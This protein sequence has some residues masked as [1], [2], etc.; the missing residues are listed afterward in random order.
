MI[1]TAIKICTFFV[2]ITVL[3]ACSSMDGKWP[4]LTEPLPSDTERE[5]VSEQAEPSTQTPPAPT[6]TTFTKSG[7]IKLFIR[8]ETELAVAKSE[9]NQ[10][11][12]TVKNTSGETKSI[13]WNDAQLKLTRYSNIVSNLDA[14]VDAS[15]LKGEPVWKNAN[16]LKT[17]MDAIIAHH[18]Q[19]LTELQ[20]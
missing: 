14:I 6:S 12:A 19:E 17:K 15:T 2:T 18:R 9:F 1:N 10:A 13:A 11:L 7:A 4:S 20:P 8:T 5:R 3:S 16:T